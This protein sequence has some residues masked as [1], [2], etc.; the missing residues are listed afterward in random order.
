MRVKRYV[1]EIK[2]MIGSEKGG[3]SEGT[4]ICLDDLPQEEQSRLLNKVFTQGMERL[5]YLTSKA[6]VSPE[7]LRGERR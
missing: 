1:T 7:V 2:T 6:A 5:G 3:G 4:A